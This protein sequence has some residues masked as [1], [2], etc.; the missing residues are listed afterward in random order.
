MRAG[1]AEPAARGADDRRAVLRVRDPSRALRSPSGLEDRAS[2]RARARRS[3]RSAPRRARHATCWSGRT[4]SAPSA[5]MSRSCIQRP[6]SSTT[7][8]P[9]ADAIASAPRPPR[10]FGPGGARGAGDQREA[11]VGERDRAS[12]RERRR[13]SPTRAGR[14]RRAGRS[15][16]TRG[17]ELGRGRRAAVAG[18]GRPTRRRSRAGARACRSARPGWRWRRR[19]RSPSVACRRPHRRA[20]DRPR[21]G[22]PHCRRLT[23]ALRCA[24]GRRSALVGVE[25]RVGRPARLDGGELPGEVVRVL[26]ARVEAEAAGG[27][28]AMRGVADQEDAPLAVAL[29]D[30]RGHRPGADRADGER[31][32]VAVP[33]ARRTM[34]A[35]TR[36]RSSRATRLRVRDPRGA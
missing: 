20:P 29:G 13:A 33:M 8:R 14:A 36:S 17:P 26:H 6:S 16:R 12:R 35:H 24:T 30:L 31:M 19:A 32:R 25:Q 1:A 23:S 18:R 15:A 11:V 4:S 5:S 7:S 9:I 22:A 2:T 21:R 27:R 34:S 10:R 28:E 3:G